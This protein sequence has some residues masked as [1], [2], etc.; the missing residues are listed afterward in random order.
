MTQKNELFLE[1][2]QAGIWGRQTNRSVFFKY[3]QQTDQPIPWDEIY[4]L[5]LRQSVVGPV[6][7]GLS[8]F[9]EHLAQD[10][11]PN[12]VLNRITPPKEVVRQFVKRVVSIENRYKQSVAL[13]QA[14]RDVIPGS[15]VVGK[16]VG[17][18]ALYPRPERRFSGDIDIL[19]PLSGYETAKQA[20][21]AWADDRLGE[22]KRDL[23]TKFLKDG[24]LL[25][26]HGSANMRI[27]EAMDCRLNVL[28]EELFQES[29]MARLPIDQNT[30]IQIPDASFNAVYV[31][32]HIL[33][34]FYRGGIGIKAFC[35]WALLMEKQF[36]VLSQDRLREHVDQMCL[37]EEWQG[38]ASFAVKYLGANPESFLFLESLDY[39]TADRIFDFVFDDRN[40]VERPLPK[41]YIARKLHAFNTGFHYIRKT[42]HIFP[43][44]SR[45]AMA[46]LLQ[47]GIHRGIRGN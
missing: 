4:G 15:F 44:G 1:L 19:V 22:E 47:D 36:S 40:S 5:S 8:S 38:I 39:E 30:S 7:D 35:D 20:I 45:R 16:G 34:H 33:H 13:A 46:F 24:I 9:R 10:N 17:L 32:A 23:E 2:L 18:A 12:D 25:E 26:L 11:L 28:K 21:T 29:R 42:R 3:L 37:W 14:L 27:T 41:R 6:A 43:T 31:L